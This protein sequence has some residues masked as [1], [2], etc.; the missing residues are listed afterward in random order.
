MHLRNQLTVSVCALGLIITTL[1]VVTGQQSPPQFGGGYAA[2][3]EPRQQLVSNWVARFVKT[4]GQN[5]QPG[6]FYDDL[7]SVSTKTTFEAV[8]H[9]LLR[10]RLS[11]SADV[12]IGDALSLVER[13]DSV[14]GE[15]TGAASD[16]QFRMYVRLTAGAL[17]ALARSQQFKRGA[18]NSVYHKGYPTNYRAQGGVPSVQISIAPD[19]RRADIDVDY[20][21]SSFPVS[22]LNGHLTSS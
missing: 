18:D 9:A 13:V 20:R 1:T 2:L 6:A 17:D 14:R 8:T 19:G 15:V 10:I 7:L 3:D 4:T 5:V 16:Q 11:D 12:T 21:G 22:L